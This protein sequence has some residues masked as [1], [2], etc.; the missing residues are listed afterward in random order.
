MNDLLEIL[1]ALSP[2]IILG[3]ILFTLIA[4]PLIYLIHEEL[5]Y[6]KLMKEEL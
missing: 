3:A 1:Y 6:K 2:F 5:E 4:A